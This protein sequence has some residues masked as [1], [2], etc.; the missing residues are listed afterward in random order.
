M[1]IP[2]FILGAV[3]TAV[4]AAS[5]ADAKKTNE[6]AEETVRNAKRKYDQRKSELEQITKNTEDSLI[7]LGNSKKNVLE[8]S[9]KE[10]LASYE[11]IKNINFKETTGIEELSK[12]SITPEQVLEIKKMSDLYSNA[13]QSGVAGAATGATLALAASGALPFIASD[14]A[15]AGASLIAGDLGFASF[16]AGSALSF[17]AS[18]TPLAAIAAPIVLFTGLSASVKA[19]ENYEKASVMEAESRL[20]C[21]KMML[22]ISKC[23]AI[24]GKSELFYD[25]LEELNNMFSA[26][27]T[28]FSRTIS[29]KEKKYS[30][31]NKSVFSK[32]ELYLIAVTRSLAGAVKAV[33]DVPMLNEDGSIRN[34]FDEF[35]TEMT[36]NS[37]MYHKQVDTIELS[38]YSSIERL[39]LKNNFDFNKQILKSQDKKLAN[40]KGFLKET[41]ELANVESWQPVYYD[42]RIFSFYQKELTIQ[43][44]NGKIQTLRFD[45]WID[46]IDLLDDQ[47]GVVMDVSFSGY[48]SVY[49]YKLQHEEYVIQSKYEKIESHN[50]YK[51]NLFSGINHPKIPILDIE[52]NLIIW[53]V[54]ER[55][56]ADSV[57]YLTVDYTTD[58]V[59]DHVNMNVSRNPDHEIRNYLHYFNG[60]FYFLGSRNEKIFSSNPSHNHNY[61][62]KYWDNY[63]K[64]DESIKWPFVQY[65]THGN[66]LGDFVIYKKF[67]F[68]LRQYLWYGEKT[69]G[70]LQDNQVAIINMETG[71]IVNIIGAYSK[72]DKLFIIGQNLIVFEKYDRKIEIF[73]MEKNIMTKTI[74]I[75]S[76]SRT[77]AFVDKIKQ[78]LI[79]HS[80]EKVYVYG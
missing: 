39:G 33:I 77:E 4:G 19:D 46:N 80:Y 43:H 75:D 17:G 6:M 66:G 56:C 52:R 12:L 35:Y 70:Y 68:A 61:K 55:T 31:I 67:M 37:I 21:E 44:Q 32:E 58:K 2:L 57:C 18:M 78:Q 23:R 54:G 24:I 30:N 3:A 60:N 63:P 27:V 28:L 15:L 41:R 38:N 40:F 69:G 74:D 13:I 76:D 9:M 48:A 34:G 16:L 22:S 50:Q 42:G 10:F 62:Y 72:I 53:G 29:E 7:K 49:I 73:D 1:P 79:I 11:K 45:Q 65:P 36:S 26:C 64:I 14:L 47:L 8:H 25:L 20:A 51:Y 71:D 59:K 5:T